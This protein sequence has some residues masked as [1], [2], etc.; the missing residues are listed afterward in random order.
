MKVAVGGFYHETN[1]RAQSFTGLKEFD[2]YQYVKGNALVEALSGTNSEI[3][4]MIDGILT[5][6][7]IPIPLLFASAV[8]SGM[9]TKACFD[10]LCS[11]FLSMLM[12]AETVDAVLLSLHGAAMVETMSDPDC[13]F[14]SAVRQAIGPDIPIGVTLDYH[15]NVSERLFSLADFVSI[16]RTYPHTD[17]AERGREVS[18]VILSGTKPKG[19]AYRKI[20]V[21]TVPL[22]QATADAP[23][24]DIMSNLDKS[25]SSDEIIS[26]SIAMG[27]AYADSPNLGATILAYAETQSAADSLSDNLAFQIWERRSEF[28]PALTNLTDLGDA[29][30]SANSRPVIIVDPADN[31]GGGSAGDGTA[32]LEVLLASKMQG[33]IVITDPDV[34][35]RANQGC[36]EDPFS[37]AVGGK[38]DRLHGSPVSITGKIKWLG[39]AKFTNTGSY[40]TGFVTSMGLTAVI[41]VDGLNIVVTS[42]RTMP[43]DVGILT[44]VDIDPNDQHVIVVKSA[45]AWQ[46]A[47]GPIAGSTVLVDTPGICPLQVSRDDFDTL[48]GPMWPIDDDVT[49][50][51]GGSIQ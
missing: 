28:S 8:P 9:I 10:T 31:I 12:D 39:D 5:H 33:T 26:A 38:T 25:V 30:K 23:M 6:G 2:A 40:M 1:T 32:I 7:G 41:D 36:V 29:L 43:F 17:M 15:A 20:P 14:V 21:I 11:E 18:R 50:C 19:R 16:Y 47:F 35:A 49:F 37:D 48:D 42:Y 34:A 27:F 3:G 4:G 13:S 46:A 51:V 45:I 44:A 24:V 22:V